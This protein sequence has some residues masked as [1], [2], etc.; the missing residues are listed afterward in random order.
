MVEARGIDIGEMK[1]RLIARQ[2]EVARL[3]EENAAAARPVELD[4]ARV[5]RL[6]RMDALQV[7]EMAAETARRRDAELN[8]IAA[9]LARIED[10]EFGWCLN[11]GEKIGAKRLLNDP[12]APNCIGCAGKTR[13]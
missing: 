5:G 13:G 3:R 12:A 11:C 1:Q 9:A 2:A 7:K 4:Q 8:R 10:G 6:S